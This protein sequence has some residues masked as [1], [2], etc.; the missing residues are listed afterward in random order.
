MLAFLLIF[1]FSW[2]F[3][4]FLPWWSA[5][6]SGFFFGSWLLHD[7]TRAFLFG[8]AAAG[9]AWLAHALY[10]HLASGGILT[11]RIAGMLQTGSSAV[12]LLITFLI[13]ALIGGFGTLTGCYFGRIRKASGNS[14]KE[15][16]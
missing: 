1:L 13:G 4:L 16:M 8:S 3:L 6:L 7:A 14:R 12:I 10:I 11:I 2:L 15:S 5:A 9:L